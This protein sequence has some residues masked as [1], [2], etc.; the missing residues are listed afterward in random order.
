M[1]L[2]LATLCKLAWKIL[3]DHAVAV[4]ESQIVPHNRNENGYKLQQRNKK[5]QIFHSEALN[6]TVNYKSYIK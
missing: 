1:T 5:K 4:F 3:I 2:C 6:N